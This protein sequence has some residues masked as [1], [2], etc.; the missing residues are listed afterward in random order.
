MVLPPLPLRSLETPVARL[1]EMVTY[2]SFRGTKSTLL[3]SRVERLPASAGCDGCGRSSLARS[4]PYL[5]HGLPTR[6]A[7]VEDERSVG[8]IL[9]QLLKKIIQLI[10]ENIEMFILRVTTVG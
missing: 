10:I 7:T 8:G 1:P 3:P 6:M 5:G 4:E 2:R 9:T